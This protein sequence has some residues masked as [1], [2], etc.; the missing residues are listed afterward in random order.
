MAWMIGI[1]EAGY[2]PNLG[3]L[4]IGAATWWVDDD[5]PHGNGTSLDTENN[6]GVAT[7]RRSPA[8]ARNLYYR[9]GGVVSRKVTTRRIAIADSK[10]LYQPGRGL[11]L[12]ERGVL[13]SLTL[14]KRRSERWRDLLAS[15]L[16]D[17][18][19][20]SDYDCPLPCALVTDEIAKLAARLEAG[21]RRSRCRLV[22]LRTR[23]VFPREFNTLTA[24]Y[25]TKGAALS[26]VTIGLLREVMDHLP[27]PQ[28]LA[29]SP[30]YITCDK[31]GG[32]NHYGALLQH[33]FPEHWIN[34][35]VETRAESRYHWQ[36]DRGKVEVCIRMEGEVELPTALA[37]MAAKYH[38]ELAM[39]AF[40][41]YWCRVVPD[42][43]P[44][45]GYPVDSRRFKL[46]IAN[47]QRRLGISDADL[48]R[49]R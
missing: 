12:L 33:H 21:C 35:L 48:W 40:N 41:D 8:L 26:H 17:L 27:S 28:P 42:L 10:L 5:E 47:D 34:T 16:P 20:Y 25:G 14:L 11:E 36:S 45:A 23:L 6:G 37:S 7:L 13:T 49:E 30:C 2:G 44:T 4:V 22:D 39:R 38:R 32:R 1:D 31:H 24:T 43:R 3:P 46:A 19:W 9:L 29:S 18:P 15:H